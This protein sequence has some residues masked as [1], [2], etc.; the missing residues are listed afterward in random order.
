MMRRSVISCVLLCLVA[1]VY[2][3]TTSLNQADWYRT[4]N[5]G[6]STWFGGTNFR[7]GQCSYQ[8][9]PYGNLVFPAAIDITIYGS[10][11]P[12]ASCGMCMLVFGN[13][14]TPQGGSTFADN[15]LPPNNQPTI[16]WVVDSCGGCNAG[17]GANPGF[18]FYSSGS[19]SFLTRWT[20]I[21]CPVD[22]ASGNP[23]S[24]VLIN[25]VFQGG[26]NAYYQKLQL[27]GSRLPVAN[28][29]FYNPTWTTAYRSTRT[30]DNFWEGNINTS[31]WNVLNI[32]FTA[33][34][35]GQV[36][37]DT[38][39]L[40]SGGTTPPSANGRV[41]FSQYR[42]LSSVGSGPVGPVVTTAGT[43]TSGS[44]TS[45]GGSAS[46]LSTWIKGMGF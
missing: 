8:T 33:F 43:T 22:S 20:A 41:Q 14:S 18:D 28:L 23:N 17:N 40:Q 15:I 46:S 11:I 12:G 27:V 32:Q 42:L 34:G 29:T 45:G 37:N 19:G 26:A 6:K 44:G 9:N 21:D 31:Q 5:V 10:T 3:Q 38:I 2:S 36:L 4:T 39:T 1:L 35:T 16:V 25:Y 24:N 13:Q 7:S 30:S